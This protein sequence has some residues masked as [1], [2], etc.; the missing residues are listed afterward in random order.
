MALSTEGDGNY[1]YDDFL[2]HRINRSQGSSGGSNAVVGIANV[3]RQSVL[4][5]SS[6][7]VSLTRHEDMDLIE[8]PMIESWQWTPDD[9]DARIVT[10]PVLHE[11]ATSDQKEFFVA[12]AN[13]RI[14]AISITEGKTLWTSDMDPKMLSTSE[15]PRI[16]MRVDPSGEILVVT[17]EELVMAFSIDLGKIAF[18]RRIG[19]ATFTAPIQFVGHSSGSSNAVD[20]RVILGDSTGLIHALDLK[21]GKRTWT[22]QFSG[23]SR[24]PIVDILCRPASDVGK[25]AGTKGNAKAVLSMARMDTVFAVSKTGGTV[26]VPGQCFVTKGFGD[27]F[28]HFLSS[29]IPLSYSHTHTSIYISSLKCAHTRIQVALRGDT[30]TLLWRA[31]VASQ[32]D[33]TPVTMESGPGEKGA[34][35]DASSMLLLSNDQYGGA[36]IYKIDITN[37]QSKLWTMLAGPG[38]VLTGKIQVDWTVPLVYVVVNSRVQ[39]YVPSSPSS[40]ATNFQISGLPTTSITFSVERSEPCS[41]YVGTKSGEMRLV[42]FENFKEGS[43]ACN[44]LTSESDSHED[45]IK[46]SDQ[47]TSREI[48]GE[49]PSTRT[50]QELMNQLNRIL[51]QPKPV[52]EGDDDSLSSIEM[53]IGSLGEAVNEEQSSEEEPE[54]A[55]PEAGDQDL[56]ANEETQEPL[57]STDGAREEPSIPAEVPCEDLEDQD[58]GPGYILI[59]ESGKVA[60]VP[61]DVEW[62]PDDEFDE[63][64]KRNEKER[65]RPTNL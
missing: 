58:E 20:G 27:H 43:S 61:E 40:P 41:Y 65:T 59:E 18:F 24:S 50:K 25:G 17:A 28:T 1:M 9:S 4:V 48:D 53:E 10:G 64:Q 3:D 46:A 56:E 7:G 21:Y 49:I 11:E 13:Y 54:I 51:L 39:V 22:W 29:I 19:P 14:Y 23:N 45:I 55:F 52:K 5:A 42:S 36:Q 32:D 35:L 30:A 31:R 47:E 44:F 6:T 63:V 15:K 62:L 8:D 26:S 38:S 34:F 12:D 57:P 16:Q 37:G 2:A 33:N 60:E